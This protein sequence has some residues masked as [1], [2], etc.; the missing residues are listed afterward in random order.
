MSSEVYQSVQLQHERQMHENL[1][2]Q[3]NQERQRQKEQ[4]RTL[5]NDVNSIKS[6]IEQTKKQA[7][8]Q[9]LPAVTT[10][11]LSGIHNTESREVTVYGFDENA[12]NAVNIKSVDDRRGELK[13]IDYSS[14]FQGYPASLTDYEQKQNYILMV[15]EELSKLDVG[16]AEQKNQ[17]VSFVNQL[18]CDDNIDFEYFKVLVDHR[19]ELL[20]ASS[21][22]LDADNDDWFEYLALCG[23]LHMKPEEI[24]KEKLQD[25]NQKLLKKLSKEKENEFV[26]QNLKEVFEELHMQIVGE[27]QLDGLEG[28]HI[29]NEDDTGCSVFMSQDSEGVI[30]ETMVEADSET[31]SADRKAR[32][33]ESAVKMCEKHKLII[34]K[35]KERGII[36]TTEYEKRPKAEQI[37]TV[38]CL[39]RRSG[40]RGRA[41]GNKM[42]AR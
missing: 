34:A 40:S 28:Q 4:Y 13:A 8:G 2:Q 41:N 27:L 25:M 12:F 38:D 35:M 10:T 17:L 16:K 24:K 6:Q 3:L 18:L 33:E 5:M 22:N 9:T 29:V 36:L 11:K 30:F 26:S 19:M 15:N 31:M 14:V 32:I 21:V 37:R 39:K 7:S 1:M 42:E 20:H 23:M